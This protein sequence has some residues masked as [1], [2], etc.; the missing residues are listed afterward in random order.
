MFVQFEA[1]PCAEANCGLLGFSLVSQAFRLFRSHA[2][3]RS[4]N[5]AL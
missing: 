4:K 1:N 5:T 2:F 3:Q